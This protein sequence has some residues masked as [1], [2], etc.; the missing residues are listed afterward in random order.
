[1]I[2]GGITEDA[3]A[4][5]FRRESIELKV[6]EKTECGKKRE[7]RRSPF[8]H[9]SQRSFNHLQRALDSEAYYIRGSTGNELVTTRA[10]LRTPVS[11]TTVIIL[12]YTDDINDTG[13]S[14]IEFTDK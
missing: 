4:L 12:N 2:S 7:K 11:G 14:S 6:L 8:L 9:S 10:S 5:P 1:M 13:K 3:L